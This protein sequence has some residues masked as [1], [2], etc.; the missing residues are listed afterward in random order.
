M[1]LALSINGPKCIWV[2][3]DRRLSDGRGRVTRDDATKVMTLQTVDAQAVLAYTGLGSTARGT[4]PAEWMSAVLRGRNETLEN[5]ILI[6]ADAIQREFPR[7]LLALQGSAPPR[8]HVL[9]SAF[10]GGVHRVYLINMI[11]NVKGQV[12]FR[13]GPLDSVH[14]DSIKRPPRITLGGSGENVLVPDQRWIRPLLRMVNAHDNGKVSSHTVADYLAALN[15]RVHQLEPTVGPDCIVVWRPTRLGPK[16][17]GG[18]QPY[19]NGVRETNVPSLPSIA[20]GLD[21][22]AFTD[23]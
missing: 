1:T 21:V 19:K 18:H 22:K 11:Y 16:I 23:V 6:V 12:H 3:V 10:V 13:A 17:G 7:H 9:I 15:V 8:H 14:R 20:M 2:L 5:S 4:Q